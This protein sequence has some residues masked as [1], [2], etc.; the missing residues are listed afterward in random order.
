MSIVSFIIVGYLNLI[1]CNW[2]LFRGKTRHRFS[3]FYLLLF[4]INLIFVRYTLYFFFLIY[5]VQCYFI[6]LLVNNFFLSMML[7]NLLLSINGFSFFLTFDLPRYLGM[8]NIFVYAVFEVLIATYLFYYMS[9]LDKK[10]HIF[11]YFSGYTKKLKGLTIFSTILIG[12]LYVMHFTFNFYSLDYVLTS[13]ILL[14]Y[15][16]F[17]TVLFV[18]FVVYQRKFQLLESYL[19]D[20]QETSTYYAK[21]DEFRHDYLNYIEALEY[22]LTNKEVGESFSMLEH[23]KKYSLEIIDDAR[24]DPVK[25]IND[26]AIRGLLYDFIE[27]ADRKKYPYKITVLNPVTAI[28]LDYI[29]LI[30]LFS[31]ALNNAIEH[32]DSEVTTS[33][34]ILIDQTSERFYFKIG[35]P[36]K[37][38]GVSLKEMLKRGYSSKKGGGLGLYN[39]SKI[40]EKYT[41][42]DYQVTYV[43]ASATFELELIIYET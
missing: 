17:Y 37:M 42:A 38:N 30:R 13:I 23:L 26:S 14:L 3:I 6:Y 19:K 41:N 35:N 18:V 22:S 12:I 28:K 43:K 33:I 21:L 1:I 10:Y 29:D 16:L 5:G 9:L 25:K 15:H 31:I 7:N 11:D 39:F 34:D 2:V 24:H 8:F 36:A 32:Y 4:V 20:K 27:K 40:I